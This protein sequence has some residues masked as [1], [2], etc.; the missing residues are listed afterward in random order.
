MSQEIPMFTKQAITKKLNVPSGQMW[1]A[2]SK[3]GRLDVWFPFIETCK[4]EGDGPGALR[5]MTIAD[6]GGDIKDTIEEVDSKNMKLIYLRP[7]SPFPVSYYKGT[8]EVF[9]SYDGLGIV[10]W[11]IDFESK[12]EDSAS[13]AEL[14][15]GAISA[16]IDGMEIDLM[17]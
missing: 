13:V 3:I 4:V 15:Q 6:K 14:V 10:V 17:K 11:T 1:E 12:P 8:V 2:I 16:G 9:T 5:Y 7:I